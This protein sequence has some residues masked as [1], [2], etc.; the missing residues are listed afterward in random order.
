[1]KA[2]AVIVLALTLLPAAAGA[3]DLAGTWEGEIQDPRRP[4]V[5]SADFAQRAA[6]LSGS[7]DAVDIRA[8]ASKGDAIRFEFVEHGQTFRFEGRRHGRRIRGHVDVAPDDKRYSFWLERLPER[9]APRHRTE[10]WRQDL[11]VVATRFLRHDRSFSRAEQ[12][13]A[14]TRLAR[15]AA[16]VSRRSDAQVM[17]ELGRILALAGNAHTRLFLVRHRTEVRRLPIRVW[18]FRDELRVVRATARH[19]DL[20]GCRIARIGSMTASAAAGRVRGI[21]AGNATWQL[22]LS[23]YFLTSPDILAAV[24]VLADAERVPLD[25]ECRG[26][27]RAVD[28]S[29][30]PLV[31]R[32]DQVEAWWDL[33]PAYPHPQSDLEPALARE[34]APRYLRN[35][36]RNYWFT[37]VPEQRAIYFQ[38]NRSREMPDIPMAKF[39]ASLVRAVDTHRPAAFVVDLRFNTGGDLTIATPMVH[40]LARRL[41]GV[42][43]FVLTGRATFSAG[44]SHAVQWM[45]LAG[46]TL[47]GERVGDELDTWS[48]GGDLVLPNSRLTLHYANAFHSYSRREFPQFRPYMFDMGVDSLEPA[49]RVSLSW[50]DYVAGRDPVYDAVAARIAGA[51]S[52][53]DH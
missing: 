45:Q 47:V 37:Y 38:Y 29:P 49:V 6:T 15:L 24:G 11:D 18:W 2:P 8:L 13:A 9:A 12:A 34:R 7:R 43:V 3:Q 53:R 25:V 28:L 52:P 32:S 14:R 19:R 1:M 44:I 40:Q 21:K 36:H 51:R 33:V 23:Q 27:S 22:Y 5:V 50:A 17:V 46:A 41:R 10:A 48:E 20:L 4:L 35:A 16:S 42:P 31:R 39:A 26:G 30:L